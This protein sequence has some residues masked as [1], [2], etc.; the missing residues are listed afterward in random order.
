MARTLLVLGLSLVA[1]ALACTPKVPGTHT[2]PWLVNC[3]AACSTDDCINGCA[4]QA[5]STA[6]DLYNARANC[7]TD[8]GCLAPNCW[9]VLCLPQA[10]ACAAQGGADGGT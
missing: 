4:E 2:C 5:T 1:V 9:E 8:A 10:Q 3:A 6:L 7:E